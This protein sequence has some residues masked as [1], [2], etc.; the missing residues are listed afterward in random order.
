MLYF[1]RACE[2]CTGSGKRFAEGPHYQLYPA[3]KP[4]LSDKTASASQ[5]E[6]INL[7]INQLTERGVMSEAALYASPFVDISPTGPEGIFPENKVKQIV[8]VLADIR[9]ELVGGRGM[10]KN[11]GA[12]SA[13]ILNHYFPYY[14]VKQLPK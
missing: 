10:V 3:G 4:F 13:D 11:S 12:K 14:K 8:S 7:I 5:I 9:K 2:I 6:F 1:I